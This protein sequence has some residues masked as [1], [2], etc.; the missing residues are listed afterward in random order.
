MNIL[1]QFN[2]F[3]KD[4][5]LVYQEDKLL[6]AVS[7][8]RDSM[9]MFWLFI[10]AGYSIEIAHCNFNLRGKESDADEDLVKAFAK[11]HHI[12]CHVKHFDTQAYAS[13]EKV[14]IQMAARSLRYSWFEELRQLR[15]LDLIAIA[16]HKNDHVET[17]LFN[18]SRGT[19]LRGLTGIQRKR[20]TIIRPL[21]FMES[22]E[23]TQVVAEKAIPYRDDLSNFS[24]KY[25]RNKIRLDII[26]EFEKLNADFIM[27]M[28]DNI[29][30]FQESIDVL[31][32][33]V[34]SLRD[35]IFVPKGKDSW[36][37]A[38]AT[39]GDKKIGLIYLLF[40][41]FNFNKAILVDLLAS[42]DKEAGRIF[43][44]EEYVILGDRE[45]LFLRKKVTVEEDIVINCLEQEHYQWGNYHFDSDLTDDCGIENALFVAK[46]DADAVRLPLTIRS[47]QEGDSFHPLGMKGKKKLSDLFIQRKVNLFAKQEVPILVNGNGEIMWVVGIQLDDRYKITE[48]T[49][50]VLKLVVHK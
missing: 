40:E 34:S 36:E 21:L 13:Q 17:V 33:F 7:G 26:P 24:T 11:A 37:I 22:K 6:L 46:L 38:K 8:G 4:N 32:D 47:W 39:I 28:Q 9:L 16:Q 3:V 5:K 42:L 44:S 1:N 14:S 27:Q 30:R 49:K 29:S 10:Q 31:D 18:L 50:K 35:Q 41:P 20:D 12:K 19:G 25:A 48:K 2:R 45:S 23:I 15:N 43:E